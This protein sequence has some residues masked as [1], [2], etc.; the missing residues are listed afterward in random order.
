MKKKRVLIVEDE[1]VV[2]ELIKAVL[3]KE[4]FDV[5]SVH[6]GKDGLAK[7]KENNFDVIL[8]DFN[9]PQMRGDE[10]YLEVKRLGKD[11]EKKII[12]VSGT[13]NEFIASTG[14][15]FIEKPFSNREL[16]EAVKDLISTFEE[17]RAENQDKGNLNLKELILKADEKNLSEAIK[18]LFYRPPS[19]EIVEKREDLVKAYISTT[20]REENAVSISKQEMICSCRESF[21][22]GNICKHILLVVFYILSQIGE[23]STETKKRPDLQYLPSLSA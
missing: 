2:A 23:G 20:E 5:V 4:G 22:Y 14:N 13:L 16:V 21:Q 15:K 10:F 19:I 7:I 12:F 6:S 1:E 11:L 8:S 18:E 3:E 9:M 17:Q